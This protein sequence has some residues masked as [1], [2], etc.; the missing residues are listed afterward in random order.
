MRKYKSDTAEYH[1]EWYAKN[2]ARRVELNKKWQ[3]GVKQWYAEYKKT[4]TC[5]RCPESDAV[6]LD[7]HHLDPTKKDY[8][9][10]QTMW[11]GAS[12]KKILTEIEKCV[13]LCANCHRKEHARLK[14]I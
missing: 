4:L 11:S 5:S 14:E 2:K 13:V 9:V 1:R 10:S 12:I 6:C 8:T 3:E 7:F